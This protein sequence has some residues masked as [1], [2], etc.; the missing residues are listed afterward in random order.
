MTVG[1]REARERGAPVPR[2]L[3]VSRL[4]DPEPAAASIRLSALRAE[5][6]ARGY[7]VDVLTTTAAP[8]RGAAGTTRDAIGRISRWPALRNSDGYVRGYLPYLSFDVPGLLRVLAAPRP[9]VLIVEPPPTTGSMV[10]LT[11]ALRRA[12]YV[13]YAAD[14]WSVAALS[15]G[16]APWVGGVVGLIERFAWQGAA[17]VLTVYPALRDRI[18][19]LAPRA[20]VELVG[21]GADTSVF[22]PVGETPHAPRPYAVYAGTAS[23]VHGAGIFIEAWRRVLAVEPDAHLVVIGQGEDRPAM[24]E[25]ART[26]PSG[27]V[28]FLPRLDPADTAAWLRGA[29]AALASVRPGPYG[30]ALATKV[31]AAAACGVPVVYVGEGEGAGLVAEHALGVVVPYETDAVV[32]ALLT[33][34]RR[35]ITPGERKRLAGWARESASLQAAAGRA[36]DAVDRLVRTRRTRSGRGG[37]T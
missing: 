33:A 27:A 5:L 31:Y 24:E 1:G 29:Q 3:L 28:T 35:E 4:F 26:L 17:V 36:A 20:H 9:D 14:I 25:A 6:G 19:A 37:Q 7:Q 12:P 10:R 15:T 34:L 18:V 8:G 23:E 11:A 21:H 30:F 2:V 16:V 22:T 13:Y 32:A